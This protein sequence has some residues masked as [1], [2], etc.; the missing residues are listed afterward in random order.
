MS[1]NI[2][3]IAIIV[4]ITV[5][6]S[7]LPSKQQE[8]KFKIINH[9]NI[10][11]PGTVFARAYEN[12]LSTTGGSSSFYQARNCADAKKVF[13]SSENAVMIYNTNVGISAIN[14][15][16]DCTPEDLSEKN[17]I[18]FGTTYYQ[19]CGTDTELKDSKTL[20]AASVVLSNG[21]INDYNN[22]GVKVKGVPYGGSKG[23]LAGVLAGDIDH[24]QIGWAIAEPKRL[25]RTL[26]CAYSTDPEADNFVG[27]EFDLAIPNLKINYLVYTNAKNPEDVAKL[28]SAI[29]TGEFQDFVDHKFI[30]NTST[31][32][33]SEN[34]KAFHHWYNFNYITY[35]K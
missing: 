32:F 1:K 22:N 16:L 21:I 33:T 15:G 17:G 20:G 31:E 30:R 35:W 26:T 24:G 3:Y 34:I 4:F 25:D 28:K 19:L 8:T 12:A 10:A 13:N 5:A 9:S 18:F 23:V 27:N 2:S 7:F 11:S 14:K 6:F 29:T